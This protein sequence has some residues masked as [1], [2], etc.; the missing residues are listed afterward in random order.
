MGSEGPPSG[1]TIP[2][3]G[4]MD[5]RVAHQPLVGWA[6]GPRRP[7]RQDLWER[8]SPS[9]GREGILLGVG[10]EVDSSTSTSF[11]TT[12]GEIPRAPTPSP[13]SY[14]Y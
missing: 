12:L 9:G 10:L 7:M 13:P 6:A 14:I 3:V 2:Q 1:P 8:E 5:L 11:R 4:H